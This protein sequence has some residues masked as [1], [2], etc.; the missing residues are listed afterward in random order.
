MKKLSILFCLLLLLVACGKKETT[1]GQIAY[2]P[3]ATAS[4]EL[5]GFVTAAPAATAAPLFTAVPPS[6]TA[7]PTPA[8]TPTPVPTP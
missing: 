5:P 7:A 4:A 8:P 3:A 2:I 1:D 6:P